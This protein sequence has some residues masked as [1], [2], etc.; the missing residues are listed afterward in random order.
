MNYS[1]LNS[2]LLNFLEMELELKKELDFILEETIALIDKF[3][4][5][6]KEEFLRL[7]SIFIDSRGKEE[8][9]FE[10]ILQTN[11]DINSLIKL[12]SIYFMLLNIAEERDE[13]R[14]KSV[15]LGDTVEKLASMG[16]S[17]ED[18]VET[19]KEIKFLPILF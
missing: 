2:H 9:N 10:N 13:I 17:R 12:F 8:V 4:P 19:F 14:R 16:F 18:I 3:A 11:E 1:N 15:N 6:I 7:R 5:N